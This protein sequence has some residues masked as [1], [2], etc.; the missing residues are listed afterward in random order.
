[1]VYH[2]HNLTTLVYNPQSSQ[3]LSTVHI[4]LDKSAVSSRSC[5]HTFSHIKLNPQSKIFSIH[6]KLHCA[7]GG[8][9]FSGKDKQI[10]IT[11]VVVLDIRKSKM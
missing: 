3:S 5:K 9:L 10:N 11:Y 1:M 2:K 4:F 6:D 8:I 7:A